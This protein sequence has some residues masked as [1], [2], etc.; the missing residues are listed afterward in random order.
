MPVGVFV[1]LATLDLILRVDHVPQP[2]EK[3]SASSQVIVAGGPATNAAVTFAFL[4]GSA[5][6]VS[7]L[8][9]H[10]LTAGIR[11]DLAAHGVEAVD[12]AADPGPPPSLSA[13]LVSEGSGDRAVVSLNDGGRPVRI[14]HRL[15][16][17]LAPARVVL[18]DGHHPAVAREALLIARHAGVPTILDGGSWSATTPELLPLCAVAVCSEV[19][20][21]PGVPAG[22]AVL[23]LLLAGGVGLAAITRGE[24]SIRWATRTHRGEVAVPCVTVTDT[25]GA[26]DVFHGAMAYRIACHGAPSTPSDVEATL[27][28]SAGLASRSC[29]TSGTRTWLNPAG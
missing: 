3:M 21:P 27:R 25:L 14:P 10:P 13:I 28:Y 4:G 11:A 6:L 18:C 24:R 5:L 23:D 19:F 9:A 22:D 17:L 20:A 26:G 16:H 12:V 1:G 8:G 7:A 29:Q 2:N 15:D